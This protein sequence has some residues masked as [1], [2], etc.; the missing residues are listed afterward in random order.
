MIAQFKTNIAEGDWSNY[1]P[2]GAFLNV[3]YW[4]VDAGTIT[5]EIDTNQVDAVQSELDANSIIYTRE[6]R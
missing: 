1:Y 6:D 5:F 4:W 2:Q 3:L